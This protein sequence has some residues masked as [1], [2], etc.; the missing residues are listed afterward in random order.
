MS[1]FTRRR[2]RD[3]SWERPKLQSEPHPVPREGSPMG[4]SKPQLPSSIREAPSERLE[5]WKEIAAY[6]K[7]DERTVRRWEGEGLP[8]HR[9]VHKK[10][11]SVYAYKEEIEAWWNEGRRRLEE[12]VPTPLRKPLLRWLLVGLATVGLA[13]FAALGTGKLLER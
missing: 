13:A 11:A 8:V 7:R 2:M 5:S 12:N 4:A 1:V 9:K 3:W 6:L 10:Q